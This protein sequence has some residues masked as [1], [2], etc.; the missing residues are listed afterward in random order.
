MSFFSDCCVFQDIYSGKLKGI[1]RLE[2]DLYVLDLVIQGNHTGDLGLHGISSTLVVNRISGMLWNRRLGH[3][4]IDTIKRFPMFNN[5]RITNC[6]DHYDICSLAKQSRLS[7][8][9]SSNKSVIFGEL[10]HADVWGPFKVLTHD[11]KRFFLT[12]MDDF[13]RYTWV[14]LMNSEDES[15]VVL[16]YFL[17]L[18]TTKFSATVKTIRT[19][20]GG[21]FINSQLK[22]L[23]IS[24][25]N[26][27]KQDNFFPRAIPAVLLG[28]SLV[29]KGYKSFYV[30]NQYVFVSMDVIFKEDQFPFEDSFPISQFES[31]AAQHSLSVP[32]DSEDLHIPAISTSKTIATTDVSPVDSPISSP[33]SSS[34][35]P[36]SS[37]PPMVHIEAAVPSTVRHSTRVSRPPG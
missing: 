26:L 32:F 24:A 25:A 2:H 37:Y 31:T 13:S 29:Q 18:M 5:A 3:V 36:A 34:Q 4:P 28:Y 8:T 16:K 9:N 1:G 17:A 15:V 33:A 12:L 7:F 23:L 22:E 20:N 14:C 19:D 27:K 10:I 30:H 35:P 11:G 21:E 6:T